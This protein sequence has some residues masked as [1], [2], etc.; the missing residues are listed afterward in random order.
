MNVKVF[1]STIHGAL[2]APPS[3][4]YTHRAIVMASLAKTARVVNP[5]YS[6]DT[7]A[8]MHACE[9]IGAAI[10]STTDALLVEGV[11]GTPQQPD[12]VVDCRNSGTTLRFMAA[13]CALIDG[14]SVLTGDA[15]LRTR[16]SVQLIEALNA[17]GAHVMSTKPN[18]TAPLIV[19]GALSGGTADISD[20]ISSQFVSSLLIACPLC[21][22]DTTLR[23]H[24]LKSRPY[25][26]ITLELL[27]RLQVNVSTDYHE[28]TI[29]CCQQYSSTDLFIP[30]DFSSAAFH[31]SAAA[32]TNSKVTV[33]NLS[34][35]K[36][37]DE[38]I[39][40]ILED[41][42][43]HLTR[44]NDT[45][46]VDG[47]ELK[48]TVIDAGDVPDLVPVLA[49]LGAYATGSTEI[50]NV[51]HLRYK[52]TDRL[53]AMT[54]ELH[55][56]GISI[57]NEGDRLQIKGGKPKGALVQGYGDHRIVMALSVAA[58]AAQGETE[59]QDA[60]SVNVSYPDFFDDLF[61]LG[62][63]IEPVSVERD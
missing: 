49:V 44:E 12:N 42:G 11:E 58:L 35:S 33:Q 6:E 63:D 3:K 60:E 46:V 20:P 37:G 13:V 21:E 38:K 36:Q 9:A 57:R 62:A 15:S 52:E 29:P 4:S 59:I 30:G 7:Y 1:P 8:T 39:V 34:E 43:A 56:M 31:L 41:M 16:P 24:N 18:G 10:T 48:G 28:F 14:T 22:L 27:K 61:A 47:A 50:H 17:L 32:I 23:V 54:S 45:V 55:K 2:A 51:S 26:D 5:L 25:I 40:T 19:R 53:A